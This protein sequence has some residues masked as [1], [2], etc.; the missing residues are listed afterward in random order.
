MK[1]NR[2]II[3]IAIFLVGLLIVSSVIII[4]TPDMV[5]IDVTQIERSL[6]QTTT[7]G[8]TFS[9]SDSSHARDILSNMTSRLQVTG[10]ISC[11]SNA[12]PFT[13]YHYHLVFHHFGFITATAEGES[14]GCQILTITYFGGIQKRYLAISADG[15]SF[16]QYVHDLDHTPLPQLSLAG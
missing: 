9:T 12:I 10:P 11:P 6:L 1:K 14:W 16:W 5:Q 4:N 3:I 8:G 7:L 13:Y 15:P 2:V